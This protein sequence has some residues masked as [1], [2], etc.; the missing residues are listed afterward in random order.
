MV[1]HVFIFLIS[2][3]RIIKIKSKTNTSKVTKTQLKGKERARLASWNESRC[4]LRTCSLPGARWRALHVWSRLLFAGNLWCSYCQNPACVARE[5]EFKQVRD[6]VPG[7]GR[8]GCPY[9]LGVCCG[10][11]KPHSCEERAQ[12]CRCDRLPGRVLRG[13]PKGLG[14]LSVILGDAPGGEG[15]GGWT[16]GPMPFLANT[17]QTLAEPVWGWDRVVAGHRKIDC[18]ITISIL[19]LWFSNTT[20]VM[21]ESPTGCTRAPAGCISCWCVCGKELRP[22]SVQS[23]AAL[24]TAPWLCVSR[25][26]LKAQPTRSLWEVG[27]HSSLLKPHAKTTEGIITEALK[28]VSHEFSLNLLA[29]ILWTLKKIKYPSPLGREQQ[30][31]FHHKGKE[32]TLQIK[33][34]MW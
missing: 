26:D 30:K 12:M 34:L 5:I 19:K 14:P 20:T 24:P 23:W 21:K 11:G 28:F 1:F 13:F 7:V 2:T 22:G 16:D 18:L 4:F 33:W 17:A 25:E 29:G 32:L 8:P 9:F 31:A 10:L 27:S 15:G 3:R 6:L